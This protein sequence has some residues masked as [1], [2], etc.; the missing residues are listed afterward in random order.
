M[1][2]LF[3]YSIPHFLATF[4]SLPNYVSESHSKSREWMMIARR[5]RQKRAPKR[6]AVAWRTR[7]FIIFMILAGFLSVFNMLHLFH[8]LHSPHNSRVSRVT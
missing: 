7:V 8:F 3:P 6:R 1:C 2:A 5:Y 4:S